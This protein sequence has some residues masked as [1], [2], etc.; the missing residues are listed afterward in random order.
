MAITVPTPE[1][2]NSTGITGDNAVRNL[3]VVEDV[4][5]DDSDQKRVSQTATDVAGLLARARATLSVAE[6]SFTEKLEA[7][8][9]EVRSAESELGDLEGQKADVENL[10]NKR[11]GLLTQWQTFCDSE[12][13]GVSELSEDGDLSQLVVEAKAL[14]LASE[15]E[16]DITEMMELAQVLGEYEKPGVDGTVEGFEGIKNQLST[17]IK[18]KAEKLLEKFV[19]NNESLDQESTAEIEKIDGQIGEIREKITALMNE[20]GVKVK[21]QEQNHSERLKKMAEDLTAQAQAIIPHLSRIGSIQGKIF[22]E[23]GRIVD[24]V[25]VDAE[26]PTDSQE[27]KQGYVAK[28]EQAHKNGD[29]K[30]L[31]ELLEQGAQTLAKAI[32]DGVEFDA[33]LVTPFRGSSFTP[34]YQ[35][36]RLTIEAFVKNTAEHVKALMPGTKN[37]DGHVG[38]DTAGAVRSAEKSLSNNQLLIGILGNPGDSKHPVAQALNTKG[39]NPKTSQKNSNNKGSKKPGRKSRK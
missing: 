26:T 24:S 27:E 13:E 33:D 30:Q 16:D 29:F 3:T 32:A 37:E 35:E 19:A 14:S 9:A 25:E 31:K 21:V 39:V 10:M 8:V 11:Q 7:N 36:A 22:S 23:V 4:V 15:D 38:T 5:T 12:K 2:Q 18:T 17:M 20:P 1:V 6:S 34:R 28:L